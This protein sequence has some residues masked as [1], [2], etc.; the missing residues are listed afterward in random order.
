MCD[1]MFYHIIINLV[2]NVDSHWDVIFPIKEIFQ[3]L[4]TGLRK[5][6]A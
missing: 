2:K 6:C 1:R 4:L 5:K 3:A